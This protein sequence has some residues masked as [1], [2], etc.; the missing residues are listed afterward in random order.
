M[1]IRK[2]S[3]SRAAK[4]D[5]DEVLR[6]AEAGE[7]GPPE[8]PQPTRSSVATA[9]GSYRNDLQQYAREQTR[10]KRLDTLRRAQLD[11]V[12]HHHSSSSREHLQRMRDRFRDTF[13]ME[14]FRMSSIPDSGRPAVIEENDEED[15]GLSLGRYNM[16]RSKRWG[17]TSL[18]PALN[19]KTDTEGLGEMP[20]FAAYIAS[21][22]PEVRKVEKEAMPWYIR[23]K[24]KLSVFQLNHPLNIYF[25][26]VL[27]GIISAGLDAGM[28]IIAFELQSLKDVVSYAPDFYVANYLVFIFYTIIVSFPAYL[29]VEYVAPDAAGSGIPE[30]KTIIAGITTINKEA[31]FSIRTFFVKVFGLLAILGSGLTSGKEG[32]FVHTSAIVARLLLDKLDFFAHL[33]DDPEIGQQVYAAAAA[34]GVSST[35]GA[36]VGGV[37]FSI[38]VTAVYYMV[39]NYW[40]AILTAAAGGTFLWLFRPGVFIDITNGIDLDTYSYHRWEYPLFIIMGILAG[41]LGALFVKTFSFI[42]DSRRSENHILRWLIGPG[43]R[44]SILVPFVTGLIFFPF[45][46][47]LTKPLSSAFDDLLTPN[48]LDD[49]SLTKIDNWAEF[50]I[51]GGLA[52]FS[53]MRFVTCILTIT[54]RVPAGLFLPVL[55]IGASSGRLL[56]EFF[57]EVCKMDVSPAGYAL[58]GAAAFGAGVTRTVSSAVIMLEMTG[59]MEFLLP[60]LL[61]AVVASEVGNTMDIGIYDMIMRKRRLPW[62]IAPDPR[63]VYGGKYYAS[64]IM[65]NHTVFIR[66]YPTLGE[67][68]R[69]LLDPKKNHENYPVVSSEEDMYLI[70]EIS[71]QSLEESV[72][73]FLRIA[74]NVDLKIRPDG[75]SLSP[76]HTLTANSNSITAYTT[77][78]GSRVKIVHPDLRDLFRVVGEHSDDNLR[79][80]PESPRARGRASDPLV[81]PSVNLPDDFF[82]QPISEVR[83]P[84]STQNGTK[85]SAEEAQET[86]KE[87]PDAPSNTR[88]SRVNRFSVTYASDEEVKEDSGNSVSSVS[89]KGRFTEVTDVAEDEEIREA[90]EGHHVSPETTESSSPRRKRSL[91]KRKNSDRAKSLDRDAVQS[92]GDA[93]PCSSA[94]CKEKK[95]GRFSIK[96]KGSKDDKKAMSMVNVASQGTLSH[97]RAESHASAIPKFSY[98]VE[99]CTP[100]GTS[101]DINEL[102]GPVRSMPHLS[103]LDVD[104]DAD[105]PKE[106]PIDEDDEEDYDDLAA[107]GRSLPARPRPHREPSPH[108]RVDSM[109]LEPLG[110]SKATKPSTTTGRFYVSGQD[111]GSSDNLRKLAAMNSAADQYGTSQLPVPS[112]DGAGRTTVTSI[113]DVPHSPSWN[114]SSLDGSYIWTVNAKTTRHLQ[115]RFILPQLI[116]SKNGKKEAHDLESYDLSKKKNKKKKKKAMKA[117]MKFTWR[118]LTEEDCSTMTETVDL[119][120]VETSVVDQS[121]YRLLDVTPISEVHTFFTMMRCDRIYIYTKQG[122]LK[123]LITLQDLIDFIDTESYMESRKRTARNKLD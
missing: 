56:G 71:R 4:E 45:G 7:A 111:P 103:A 68:A 63:L 61:A 20:A 97:R 91:P 43:P 86:T 84:S 94:D 46:E 85:D 123:G 52:I 53:L 114:E 55:C 98:T 57:A 78:S 23:L 119:L 107:Y 30:L 96:R 60:A 6:A 69:L 18:Q 54:M 31:F 40:R 37:L 121:P 47:F 90:E 112:P 42:L 33:R 25:L 26:L 92:D 35:F 22:N 27:L 29:L 74:V 1:R 62:L 117:T 36:P 115:E 5:D 50:S 105:E 82:M 101:G 95:K 113:P 51:Y 65:V 15:E 118:D 12:E 16:A 21:N 109:D 10:K 76:D 9:Y 66:R 38:E 44:Y 19:G 3:S 93:S 34:V 32:P 79:G 14:T 104:S 11:G 13:R 59:Q 28:V 116:D 99:P 49:S 89:R 41:F 87:T 39:Q 67:I 80:S 2:D 106:Q 17:S 83:E 108:R 48:P 88:G 70:G 8:P 102:T 81:R 73:K 58:V 77:R 110:P 122:R 24:E 75:I 72:N 100:Q 120:R 64:E